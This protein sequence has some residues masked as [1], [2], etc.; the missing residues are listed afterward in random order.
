MA[1]TFTLLMIYF[2]FLV[3][4][5]ILCDAFVVCNLFVIK[6]SDLLVLYGRCYLNNYNIF[7][8]LLIIIL[9]MLMLMF[10]LTNYYRGFFIMV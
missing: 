2:V 4:L 5:S 6:H 3:F 9:Y 1:F 7:I 10:I 8:I